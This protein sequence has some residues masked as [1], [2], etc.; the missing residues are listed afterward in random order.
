VIPEIVWD[1]TTQKV[2]VMEWL[3]GKPILTWDFQLPN[4][5]E[6]QAKKKRSRSV[7]DAI[8]PPY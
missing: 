3:Y 2:L 8:S 5:N 6:D 4:G 7:A 1:L